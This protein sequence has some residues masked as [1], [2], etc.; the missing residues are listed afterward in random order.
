ML[1][2][3][4]YNILVFI[5]FAILIKDFSAGQNNLGVYDDD[6][7]VILNP[8]SD[9][10]N[11]DPTVQS[12]ITD[13]YIAANGTYTTVEVI[14]FSNNIPAQTKSNIL[15]DS[16]TTLLGNSTTL[17][18]N[19]TTPANPRVQETTLFNASSTTTS[20]LSPTTTKKPVHS[21]S[22]PLSPVGPE[23]SD[24]EWKFQVKLSNSFRFFSLK[25]IFCF[26]FRLELWQMDV[27]YAM[28]SY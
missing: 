8:S 15:P 27:R 6:L 24:S 3:T 14:P 28:E 11:D 13:T 16:Q 5:W 12:T 2:L 10:N 7:E 22:A 21:I 23:P 26:I 25:L 1:D 9:Y 20:T 4:S 19:F 17:T 18:S